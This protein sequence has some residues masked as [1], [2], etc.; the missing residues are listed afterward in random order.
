MAVLD[1]TSGSAFAV[2]SAV[3]KAALR[4]LFVFLVR[5]TFPEIIFSFTHEEADKIIGL[6]MSEEHANAA[7]EIMKEKII[8]GKA[9]RTRKTKRVRS[10]ALST[11]DVTA[12]A[13]PDVTSSTAMS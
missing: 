6:F 8:S 13:E 7:I 10:A 1:V 2:T 11:A 5:S 4:T 3:D 12:N 9:E